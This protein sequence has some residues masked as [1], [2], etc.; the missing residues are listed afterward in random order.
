MT[1]QDKLDLIAAQVQSLTDAVFTGGDST[2]YKASLLSLVDD[3]PR[4]VSQ[5]PVTR[6][7]SDGK[8]VAV[9]WIQDTANAGSNVLAVLA[10]ET[11]LK[12]ALTKAVTDAIAAHPSP[13]ADPAGLADAVFLRFK[14]QYDK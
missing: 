4:R 10:N 7:G 5:L 3:I 14:S 6:T 8:P 9:P 2:P 12:D 1:N 13:V 11:G